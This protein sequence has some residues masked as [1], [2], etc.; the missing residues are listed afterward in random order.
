MVLDVML[1]DRDGFSIL[2]EIR[3]DYF[4]PVLMLTAKG[5]AIDTITGVSLGADDYIT[6]PFNSLEV[7][8]RIKTQLRRYQQYNSSKQEANDEFEK[9]GLLL[10]TTSHQCWLYRN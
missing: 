10:S 3:Q 4:F 6:K 9:E 1:P 5:E 8:A 2:Q 7:V